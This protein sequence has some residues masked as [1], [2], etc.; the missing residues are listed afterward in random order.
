MSLATF[1]MRHTNL[2]KVSDGTLLE[3][4]RRVDTMIGQSQWRDGRGGFMGR[5]A[6]V[7]LE[8]LH[9]EKERIDAAVSRRGL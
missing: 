5:L 4:Q 3:M 8:K 2:E 9:I 1:W 6:D 7:E